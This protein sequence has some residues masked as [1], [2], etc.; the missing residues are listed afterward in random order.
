MV[1]HLAAGGNASLATVRICVIVQQLLNA[2]TPHMF[3]SRE[4]VAACLAVLS[5]GSVPGIVRL[6]VGSLLMHILGRADVTIAEA[7]IALFNGEH[8]R[9]AHTVIGDAISAFSSTPATLPMSFVLYGCLHRFMM[10]KALSPRACLVESGALPGCIAFLLGCHSGMQRKCDSVMEWALRFLCTCCEFEDVKIFEFMAASEL[11]AVIMK[12]WTAPGF[13]DVAEGTHGMRFYG[14]L[15]VITRK[16]FPSIEQDV[17]SC[18]G[19]E[20]C[21]IL[22]KASGELTPGLVVRHVASATFFPKD[23][24]MEA[25]LPCLESPSQTTPLKTWVSSIIAV[26]TSLT[27]P[28]AFMLPYSPIMKSVCRLG[29]PICR[30]MGAAGVFT[31]FLECLTS[32][33]LPLMTANAIVEMLSIPLKQNFCEDDANLDKFFSDDAG[34]IQA[35]LFLLGRVSS[36]LPVTTDGSTDIRNLLASNVMRL[37][38]AFFHFT[39]GVQ[40][41]QDTIKLLVDT[42]VLLMVRTSAK[43]SSLTIAMAMILCHLAQA[44]LTRDGTEL[45]TDTVIASAAV[46]HLIQFLCNPVL[47]TDPKIVSSAPYTGVLGLLIGVAKKTDGCRIIR[48]AETAATLS[49]SLDIVLLQLSHQPLTGSESFQCSQACNLL[50]EVKP[51]LLMWSER[52]KHIVSMVMA[53]IPELKSSSLCCAI[54]DDWGEQDMAD[55]CS[56]APRPESNFLRLPCLHT[57]HTDC[58]NRWF[59]Q[60]RDTCPLCTVS[61]L[62]LISMSYA[63]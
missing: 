25:I 44:S 52:R 53:A 26:S 23:L 40:R 48:E 51:E 28:R 49:T 5:D 32:D 54:C 12:L 61:V 58:I 9:A 59:S 56:S 63:S 38:L 17:L 16:A 6:E 14:Y 33:A 29:M 2:A 41:D 21:R 36:D 34:F 24:P 46:P 27:M 30:V 37:L 18:I 39:R 62:K 15:R 1:Q 45:V 31:C 3:V 35:M 7:G 43:Q 55:S 10:M 57:Y 47:N 11:Q 50:V 20:V 42:F 22:D 19:S 60:G 13:T 8:G 4:G